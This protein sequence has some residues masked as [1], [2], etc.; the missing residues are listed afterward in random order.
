[1][2]LKNK[3]VLVTGGG[4]GIGKALAQAFGK[5]GASHVALV[6]RTVRKLQD[7]A[8][9]LSCKTLVVEA[10]IARS[11]DRRRMVDTVAKELGGLDVLVNCAG[12][13][14]A[15]SL[16]KV[17]DDDVVAM[18][19][20]NLTGL[21]LTTKGFLPALKRSDEAAIVNVSSGIGMVGMPF[22]SVYAAAKGGVAKF[23][24]SLRRELTGTSV[25]VLTL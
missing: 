1:M 25:R 17:S 7:V 19:A 2:N 10:D 23:S 15:G 16:E 11:G 21:I 13:V 24:E 22:Y 5:A 3:K 9:T 8:E 6:G 18:I 4:S 12:I 20:I 14:S